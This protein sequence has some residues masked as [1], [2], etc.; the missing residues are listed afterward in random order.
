VNYWAVAAAYVASLFGGGILARYA[1]IALKR[2]IDEKYDP[3][4]SR[5][6]LLDW[7]VGLAERAI[8]TTL[9]IWAP[10]TTVAFIG[11]WMALKFAANWDKREATGDFNA[12]QSMARHRLAG[13][14]GSAISLAVAIA[15]GLSAHPQSLTAWAK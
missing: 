1:V 8:V 7:S 9:V 15:A 5:L 2:S 3:K 6:A 14:V 12:Q 13:L 11:G 4:E 10:T